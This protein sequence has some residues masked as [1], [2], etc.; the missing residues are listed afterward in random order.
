MKFIYLSLILFTLSLSAVTQ[1]ASPTLIP[2]W[3]SEIVFEAPES[4]V[5]D[6][7]HQLLFVSNVNGKPNDA[8]GNGY[9][10]QVSLDGKIIKQHW[11][12]GLNAPKG[13]AL[14]DNMLYVADINELVA[15]DIQQH[16]ISHRY[17]APQAKFLNDVTVDNHGN[18]YVSDMMT[19]TIYRLSENKFDVWLHSAQLESPN[20]LLIEGNKLVVASWGNMTDGFATKIAGHLK[21]VDLTNKKIQSMGS[22]QPKGNLDGLEADGNGNYFVTD[23]MQGKLLY[24]TPSGISSTLVTL[25]QGSADL[26][27]LPKQNLIIVPMMLTGKLIAFKIK[28]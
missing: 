13:M 4:V 5:F 22:N 25:E 11:L 18:V 24:I 14:V 21:T 19:N 10:S 20:G 17:L 27:V 8:D 23:W 9:I 16:K 7:Q 12:D 15:I 6:A 1:A 28:K 3:Q 26:T 2:A